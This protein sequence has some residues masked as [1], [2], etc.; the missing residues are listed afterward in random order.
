MN[1]R[2]F[3]Q[4][5]SAVGASIALPVPQFVLAEPLV[6]V[7]EM[8][9][10]LGTIRAVTAYDIE[11]DLILVRL[12]AFNGRD[13]FGVDFRVNAANSRA[14][15]LENRKIAE[16]ILFEHL[17]HHKWTASDMIA[18]PTPRGYVEPSWMRA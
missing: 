13:Q 15:Y 1:R 17:K 14:S 9:I 10:R 7:P 16:Q 3:L 5:L 6:V 11:R 4:L 2:G 12:D 18:L 8:P